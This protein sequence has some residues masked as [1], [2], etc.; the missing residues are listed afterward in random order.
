VSME[1]LEAGLKPGLREC[2]LPALIE[3]AYL[4]RGGQAGIHFL[5]SMPMR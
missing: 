3:Q 5:A 2:E 1:R 4:E